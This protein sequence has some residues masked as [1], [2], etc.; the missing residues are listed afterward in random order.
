LGSVDGNADC[1]DGNV[2]GGNVG[3]KLVHRVLFKIYAAHQY[4]GTSCFNEGSLLNKI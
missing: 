1:D 3:L 4:I 2:V